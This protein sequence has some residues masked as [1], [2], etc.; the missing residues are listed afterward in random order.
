[1]SDEKHDDGVVTSAPASVMGSLL[2]DLLSEAKKDVAAERQQLER[3]LHAKEAEEREALRREEARKRAE[4]QQ[5]LTEETILRNQAISSAKR[6]RSDTAERVNPT[7]ERHARPQV[8][9]AQEA[10]L[11]AAAPVAVVKEKPRLPKLALAALVIAG[12]GLG[13]GGASA[14]APTPRL[15]MPDVD[16]AAK[17]IVALT[18]KA[19][20]AEGRVTEALESANGKIKALESKIDDALAAQKQLQDD[21]A[22]T[23]A[24]LGETKT[25]LDEEKGKPAAATSSSGSKRGHGNSGSGNTGSGVPNINTGVFGN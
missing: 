23:K 3:K 25:A 12:V 20:Q 5:K 9:P 1:M 18:A 21:L 19:A 14:L 13:F 22:K 7:T 15:T 17:S 2:T 10:P 16:A 6:D 8:A 24:E 4:M 11:T